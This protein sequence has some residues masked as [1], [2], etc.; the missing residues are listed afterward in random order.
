MSSGF[1]SLTLDAQ[2]LQCLTDYLDQ[3]QAQREAWLQARCGDHP[4]LLQAV[5]RLIA[6]ERASGDF[7]ETGPF[8][9]WDPEPVGK[10][11]GRYELMEE[12]GRGGMGVVYRARR[13]DGAFEQ[14]VA[15][16]LF[17]HGA[18]SDSSLHR[19]TTER[20]IL[21]SL[22]HPG[23]A[24][25]IDGGSGEDGVPY[26]V[27]EL[28]DGEPITHYCDRHA[29][30]LDQRLKLFHG[31]CLTLEAAHA[32]GIVHRDIK[33]GNVLATADGQTKVVDFG[34]AK[35][36][37]SQDFAAGLPETVP[38]LMALT[39]EYASP[40][41][42]RGQPI[43]PASD[44]YSLGILL[45]KL[46][47][48]SRPYVIDTL[49]PGEIER[50]VCETIPPDPSKHVALMRAA[51]PPGISDS[52]KLRGKL[53]GDL[54]RI[55]MTA[56]HK[57]PQQRYHSAAAFAGDIERYLHGLPVKA[58]GTSRLYR[59]G[60]F[61]ARN[62][63]VVAAIGFA[64]AALVAGFIAVSFQ[65][66]EA[67][68]QR[69]LAAQEAR[70]ASSAKDFLVEMI[71]RADPFENVSSA[72]LIGAIRQSISS[73]DARFAGQPQLEADMRYAIGYALQNLGEIPAAREQMEKALLLR[74]AGGS[75]L[76]IAEVLDG[77]GIVCWWESDFERGEQHFKQALE[78]LADET[79]ERA[80]ALRINTLA[81]FSGMLIDAG[82]FERS[83]D[84]SRQALEA[85]RD[86]PGISPAA[87]AAIWGNLA[88]ALDGL[89]LFDEAVAAFD[90]T[91]ELQRQA[92]GE[93]HPDYAVILNNQ[94]H[95]FHD[96]GEPQ[97][98]IAN[99]KQSL[100]IRRQTL[101]EN[102]PQVATALFNLAHVQ[103]AAGDLEDAERN[104][105][106]ALDI[107][108]ASYAEGH[109]RIGK[110]HQAL[111]ELYV[112]TAQQ[113]LARLH[114]L[115]AQH[116]Y[117]RAESVDPGWIR[118]VDKLLAEM[119]SVDHPGKRTLAAPESSP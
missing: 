30:D 19:F 7:L 12:L 65:A 11:I 75:A 115:K 63:V 58:R 56:L 55:V 51:P 76:E 98:A 89:K 60:R 34:I 10:R 3:P 73:I 82:D 78:L 31:V 57:V 100:R 105:L 72:T 25:L 81:N 13:A 103:T 39:P 9:G 35:V 70:R 114:A 28:I 47:T 92:T 108:Q 36:L 111:A 107:A 50:T 110:A 104:G 85:E 74:R 17:L 90:T 16:K 43:G 109:P 8:H 33:P 49:T 79:G 119:D 41:Q 29:L 38:G 52:R 5:L 37:R 84:L 95:L 112:S 54:D 94:A 67:Q 116:I 59:A 45:Y 21:A 96:M 71:G 18:I 15:I 86:T 102:H 2:A 20:Q 101:G 46:L 32:K 64:F 14:E 48:G 91:L 62:R 99:L 88:T 97:K 1:G 69:D 118:A 44:I 4:E 113:K 42:V 26:V 61:V 80:L 68:K 106:E 24:R 83:V 117:A 77:L 22:E 66:H 87:Q 40:E 93:L 53:R 27:M 6:V 23:I